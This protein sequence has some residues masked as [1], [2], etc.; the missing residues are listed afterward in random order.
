MVELVQP[1]DAALSP[2]KKRA[3]VIEPAFAERELSC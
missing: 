3:L 1:V 2:S